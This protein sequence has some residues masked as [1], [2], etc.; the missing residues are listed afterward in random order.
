MHIAI[1]EVDRPEISKAVARGDLQSVQKIVRAAASSSAEE[2]HKVINYARVFTEHN[3]AYTTEE[4]PLQKS[5]NWYD[6]TPLTLSAIRGHDNIV[7]YLLREGAD[8]TLKGCPYDD[9]N[10]IDDEN[11]EPLVDSPG[12]HM[13]AFDAAHFLTRTSRCCRRTEDL[14]RV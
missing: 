2:K 1:V 13:N 9:I 10:S 7:E 3:A 11:N 14:L 6:V 5:T 4:N 8:P 12:Y